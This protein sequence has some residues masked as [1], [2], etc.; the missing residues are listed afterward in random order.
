MK[1]HISRA[2]LLAFAAGALAGCSENSWNNDELN[3]F[4]VPEPT[5]VETIEYTM[6]EADYAAVSSNSANK[7]LAGDAG[8]A[9]LRAVGS[10]L[11]FSDAAPARD[12]VPAWLGSSSFA[13]F[14]L[15]DGSA[16]RLTYNTA[17]TPSEIPAEIESAT[18]Y[19]VSDEDYQT[20]W[21]SEDD[22]IAAFAPS[23]T[24]SA[25]IP[26]ILLAAL[27]DAAEG[28]TPWC[29]TAPLRLIRYSPPRRSLKS[30]ASPSP[31]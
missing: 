24:A 9:A 14:T 1:Q 2:L 30:P 23:H 22:Y 12:Y 27:P 25:S 26:G 17:V 10:K 3:G 29:A 15:T 13:Y 5:Q 31:A 7:A 19:T 28:A 20:V 4:E 8:A 16:V 18:E 21:G 6:T 11:C